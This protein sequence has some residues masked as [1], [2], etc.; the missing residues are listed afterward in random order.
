MHSL[1]S[2]LQWMCL[3]PMVGGSLYAVLC[4]LAVLRFRRC[5]NPPAQ[6]SFPEWPPVS[7]LK[8]IRGLEKNQ[9]V[10]LRSACLQDYPEFQVVFAVQERDDP[11]IPLLKEIQEEFGPEMVCVAIGN[12]QAGPNG[13]INNLLGALPHARHNLLVISDSD[14]CLEP[15]YLK[16]I[17]APLAD[18]GVGCVCTLY[19]ATCADRWFE[20]MELLTFN[21]DFIP[22]VIFAHVTGASK[23]CLGPS[24]ALRR[25]SL[26][27]MGGLET[28]SDYLVEDYEMGRRLWASGKKVAIVRYFIDL[29]VDLK[30]PF[31]WWNH[32]VYWDQNTRAAQP[33]GFF[34]SLLTRSIPFALF[35]AAFRLADALGLALLAGAVGIRLATAALTARWGL[36]DREGLRSLGLLPLRDVAGLVCWFLAFTKRTVIW[37]G[38]EFIL[39]RDGRLL[40]KE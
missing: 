5:T 1:L 38:K 15:D 3:I 18:P 6:H 35:Y 17:I 25:S 21:A 33:A 24:M 2:L 22:S 37:R 31:Q 34:A 11:A 8:P 29:V 39:I 14:V 13:K 20:K 36:Q 19:K 32:Q 16:A 28:L 23:F 4:L 27:E 40:P 10:N 26:D 12:R 7:I 30:S 9:K